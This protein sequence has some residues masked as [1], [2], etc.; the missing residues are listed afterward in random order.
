MLT[1]EQAELIDGQVFT[2]V[3][4]KAACFDG[5]DQVLRWKVGAVRRC[6]RVAKY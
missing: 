5:Q 6:C 1:C 4:G 2:G 3:G